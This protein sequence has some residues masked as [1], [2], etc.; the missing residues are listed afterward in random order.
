MI[1]RAEEF[2]RSSS[3]NVNRYVRAAL[4]VRALKRALVD[5]VAA[6]SRAGMALT[7]KQRA[8]AERLLAVAPT[9]PHGA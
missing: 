5:E 1:V 6:M 3:R 2:E 9:D 4:M 7:G 8:E